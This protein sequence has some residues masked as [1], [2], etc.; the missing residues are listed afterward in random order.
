ML[1]ALVACAPAPVEW[2]EGGVAESSGGM[3]AIG[4]DGRAAFREAPP[5]VPASVP[6]GDACPGSLVIA[7]AS[8][9]EMY[10][11][12]WAPRP[13]G[14]VRLMSSLSADGGAT[15]GDA[16]PVDTTDRGGRG[17]ARPPAAVAADSASGYI[18]V[19]YYVE[20]PDGPGLF[21]SHSMERGMLYHEPVPVVYGRGPVSAAVASDG[22]T[23]VVAYE[24][25]NT[26]RPRIGLQISRTMG[27]LFEERIPVISSGNAASSEPRVAVRGRTLAV[28]WVERPT[29][30]RPDEEGGV[31][32]VRVGEIR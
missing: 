17:C 16:V 28:G 10:G 25:P 2:V 23:V 13:D 22:N 21:F 14:S 32:V 26:A 19:V 3:L 1:A 31:P 8:A 9:S 6:A 11:I 29:G 20:G 18:H 27:H 12:W 30:S 5:I 7:R 24:D 4:A 15:W